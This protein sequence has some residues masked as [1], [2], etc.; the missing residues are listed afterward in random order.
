MPTTDSPQKISRRSIAAGAAWAVPAVL[1]STAAPAF[2]VSNPVAGCFTIDLATATRTGTQGTSGKLSGTS[3]STSGAISYSISQA[4]NSGLPQGPGTTTASAPTSTQGDFSVRTVAGAT[5]IGDSVYMYGA[6]SSPHWG[7]TTNTPLAVSSAGSYLILNQANKGSALA[8]ETLTFDFG[9]Q[10][11]TSIKFSI[12][13]IT[14]VDPTS[15]Q[16]YT[17]SVTLS[18]PATLTSS[19][20]LNTLNPTAGEAFYPTAQK[21]SPTTALPTTVTMTS[22]STS[23]FTL[24]YANPYSYS[25][26]A[27]DWQQSQYIAIGP[28]EVC[29]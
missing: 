14:R 18:A 3:T 19:S 9:G 7:S 17:D 2:A 6:T 25:G 5:N 11:P 4:R 23:G 12:Y 16:P 13:D 29:F 8:S 27:T 26:A 28:M 20:G 21:P 1:V 10:I 24:T 15:G 22:L